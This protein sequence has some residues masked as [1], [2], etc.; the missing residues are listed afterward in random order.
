MVYFYYIKVK[1]R[2]KHIRKIKTWVKDIITQ[3]NKQLHNINFIFCDDEYLLEI[4]EKYLQ[5]NYYTDII[6]FHFDNTELIDGECY[7]SINRVK[8][9]AEKFQE[10]FD[11]E[12]I[13]VV[14]HGVLHL[15]GYKDTTEQEIKTI[16]EKENIYMQKFIPFIFKT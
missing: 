16:R 2:L 15:C 13:R 5:H 1:Y 9:N 4:N 10:T 6:T 8:D 3:E 11:R 12:L 7:I 14:S